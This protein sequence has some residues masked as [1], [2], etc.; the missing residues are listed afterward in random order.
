MSHD[1]TLFKEMLNVLANVEE[2]VQ[3]R[4]AQNEIETTWQ[5]KI[6]D[7]PCRIQKL[8]PREQF[9]AI[10]GSASKPSSV[11]EYTRTLYKI[12][13]EISNNIINTNRI[14]SGGKI[15]EIIDSL[16]D[17]SLNHYELIC[18]VIES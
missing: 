3:V 15:Y 8:N 9:S 2:Q 14:L 11:G 16:S 12:Y 18:K 6:V 10:G 5:I 13:A 17:S 1:K 4:N 7:M